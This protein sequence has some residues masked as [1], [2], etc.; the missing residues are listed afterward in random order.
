MLRQTFTHIPGIGAA[1][2]ANFWQQGIHDWDHAQPERLALGP[3]RLRTFL[4]CLAQSQKHLADRNARFFADALPAAEHWRLY[5]AFRQRVAYLDIETTG[6]ASYQDHITTIALYDG[7]SVRHYVHGRNLDQFEHDIAC[8]D[9]LV[10]YNGKCFDVPFI[11]SSLG[12]C[13]PQAHLDL[14]YLL[15]NLGYAGG[16]KNCERAIGLTRPGLED[17]D[18]YVAVL[19]WREFQRTGRESVLETLLAYNVEDVLTL[20]RL[21]VMAYNM[22]VAT[23]PFAASQGLPEPATLANPFQADSVLIGR[24][25]GQMAAAP[26]WAWPR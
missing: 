23:T 17:V 26:A 18:G 10:T 15:K 3:K 19:L 4:D 1:K 20:E 2:E 24:M 12:F 22:K 6:L 5:P 8:F 7:Q 13:L 14:R 25:L 16:L 9:L 21:A 11:E